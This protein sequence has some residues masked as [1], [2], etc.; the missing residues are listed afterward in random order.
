M[1]QILHIRDYTHSQ[2]HVCYEHSNEVLKMCDS[3]MVG[4]GYEHL[5][6]SLPWNNIFDS[7]TQ[8]DTS[9]TLT[10]HQSLYTPSVHP[11]TIGPPKD[12]CSYVSPVHPT[13]FFIREQSDSTCTP[14]IYPSVDSIYEGD[15]STTDS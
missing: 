12:E 10:E 15:T 7:C 6:W 11:T 4:L 13:N 8:A 2:R 1:H 14:V 9:G 5:H 3:V